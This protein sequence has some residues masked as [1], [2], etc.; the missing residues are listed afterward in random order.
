[1]SSEDEMTLSHVAG[2]VT[3]TQFLPDR[4]YWRYHEAVSPA[5][6]PVVFDEQKLAALDLHEVIARATRSVA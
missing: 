3:R 2:I 5:F 4:T 6:D 1:M